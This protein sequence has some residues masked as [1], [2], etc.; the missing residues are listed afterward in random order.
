MQ[1]VFGLDICVLRIVYTLA[2]CFLVY[3]LRGVLLLIVLSIVAAYILFPVVEYT[4]RFVTHKRHRGGALA[5]VFLLILGILLSIGGV[6]GISA[7]QC[8]CQSGAC[9]T[10]TRRCSAHPIA[11]VSPSMGRTHSPLDAELA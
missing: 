5:I 2:V 4:Y 1:S 8:T 11:E 10:G 3:L 6:I 9:L 7:G